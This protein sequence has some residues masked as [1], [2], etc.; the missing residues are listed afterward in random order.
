MGGIFLGAHG[1]GTILGLAVAV[2]DVNLNSTTTRANIGV[3]ALNSCTVVVKYGHDPI[4][5]CC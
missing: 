2:D 3:G 4:G 5:S 1:V